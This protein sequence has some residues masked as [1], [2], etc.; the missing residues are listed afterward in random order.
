MIAVHNILPGPIPLLVIRGVYKP[1][2][3]ACLC[4]YA[5]FFPTPIQVAP[6]TPP[7]PH[8]TSSS[9]KLR[10]FSARLQEG[11]SNKGKGVEKASP[12]TL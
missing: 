6:F 1:S 5:P 11:V 4:P 7:T 8:N 12:A 2:V 9:A 3:S 10:L